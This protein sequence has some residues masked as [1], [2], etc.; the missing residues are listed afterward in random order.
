V[1]GIAICYRRED[2][3]ATAGRIY[4]RLA[5]YFGPAAVAL[6][7]GDAGAEGAG[8]LLRGAA[9]LVVVIGPRWAQL[10]TDPRDSVRLA[11]E[12]ALRNRTPLLPV[13]IEGAS[14][15]DP[16][17]LPESLRGLARIEALPV[18]NDPDFEGDVR[19]LIA[20][21]ERHVRVAPAWSP[22]PAGQGYARPAYPV[23]VRVRRQR[24]PWLVAAVAALVVLLGSGYLAAR[25]LPPR[26][27]SSATPT[28][29]AAPSPSATP[30]HPRLAYSSNM[31]TPD[32]V[33]P[34][35]A[36]CFF[37]ADGY[38]VTDGNACGGLP[39]QSELDLTVRVKYAH[40]TSLHVP[41]AIVRFRYQDAE[42]YYD[43]LIYS[44]GAW[45]FFRT[46]VN[47]DTAIVKGDVT[48]AIHAGVGAVNAIEVRARGDTFE[49]LANGTT[50]GQAQDATFLRPGGILLGASGG[51][52]VYTDFAL[53]VYE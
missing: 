27:A 16:A 20:A 19:A 32:G 44:D 1:A 13:L 26:S 6:D 28:P 9:A 2:G 17:T 39:F 15:L 35:D 22:A 31:T 37:Q 23:V 11:I 24:W 45:A 10:A 51:E 12:L 8:S 42:N 52:F 4:D 21:L 29:T 40:A 53:T 7:A 3:A 38:H 43:F 30:S 47:A 33:W 14:R 5:A 25:S 18:R 50:L 41:W 34:N 36:R 49:F 48:P 46:V